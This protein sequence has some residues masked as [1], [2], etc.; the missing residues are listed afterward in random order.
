MATLIDRDLLHDSTFDG[1]S[2]DSVLTQRNVTPNP[3]IS[4]PTQTNPAT[5][6][7]SNVALVETKIDYSLNI[8]KALKK[9]TA[10]CKQVKAEY[11]YTGGRITRGMD[12]A[13][14]ELFRTA[15]SKLYRQFPPDEGH[16]TVI[17]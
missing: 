7:D 1:S 2:Y 8:N 12:T 5:P 9:K 14:F 3:E 16:C 10:A 4:F 17:D 6:A 15:I 11:E 13:T